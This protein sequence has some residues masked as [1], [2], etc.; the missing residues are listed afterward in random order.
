MSERVVPTKPDVWWLC[1][2][3]YSSSDDQIVHVIDEGGSLVFYGGLFNGFLPVTSPCVTWLA[4]I[5]SAEAVQAAVEAMRFMKD[6]LYDQ[7]LTASNSA[8]RWQKAFSCK[9]TTQLPG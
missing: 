6:T 4:P 1:C 8:T 5:P 9:Q 3:E 2:H 7:W